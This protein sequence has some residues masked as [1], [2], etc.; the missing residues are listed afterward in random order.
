MIIYAFNNILVKVL[1]KKIVFRCDSNNEIGLGHLVRCLAVANKL[2]V[3]NIFFATDRDVSNFYINNDFKIFLKELDEDENKFLLRMSNELNPDI[4]ILDSKYPYK[5]HVLQRLKKNS[6]KILILDNICEG[7]IECDEIIFPNAHFNLDRLKDILTPDQINQ[8]RTGPKY[9]ILRE[10]IIDLKDKLSKKHEGIRIGVTTGGSDPEG[11]ILKLA[12][13]LREIN[14]EQNVYLL[15]G[16]LYKFKNKLYSLDLPKNIYILPYSLGCLKEL[17]IV[18]CTFGITA[19]EMIYLELPIIT[20]SHNKH[21]TRCAKILE[22]RYTPIE[23]LGYYQ[24]TTPNQL[25][26]ALNR[27]LNNKTTSKP[28]IDG[29]GTLRVA[30]II[31]NI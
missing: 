11:V 4:I 26:N 28:F 27:I 25:S 21:N 24:D 15:Y 19:Y 23:N 9:I 17:D 30:N 5:R 6:L 31:L 10:E 13:L 7:L 3:N 14:I 29:S 8:V 1:S 16:D 22:S 20:V 12:N 2:E 18:I